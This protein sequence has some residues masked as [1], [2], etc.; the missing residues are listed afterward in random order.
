MKNLEHH[1]IM[2]ANMEFYNLLKFLLSKE[3]KLTL[4]ISK[5]KL[6]SIMHKKKSTL[7]SLLS[8]IYAKYSK[9]MGLLIHGNLICNKIMFID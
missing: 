3:L 8:K 9:L 4:L 7:V 6:H 1:Y 5:K 2:R